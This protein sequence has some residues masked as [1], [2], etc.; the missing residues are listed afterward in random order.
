MDEHQQLFAQTSGTDRRS[1]G[2]MLQGPLERYPI[3][4]SLALLVLSL[5]LFGGIYVIYLQAV[6]SEGG[7]FLLC[8][9]AG[10]F[11]VGLFLL[12]MAVVS[13]FMGVVG[14]LR[15]LLRPPSNLCPRCGATHTDAERRAEPLMSGY[16][17][18]RCP[19]CSKE[20]KQERFRW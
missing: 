19:Q 10:M 9:I 8:A 16:V 14:V 2:T 11:A 12:L 18:L 6:Q 1:M 20:W 4:G 13:L 5:L 3:R 7:I 17:W 15:Y